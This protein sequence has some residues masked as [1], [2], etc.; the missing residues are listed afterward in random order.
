MNSSYMF[1][2]YADSEGPFK[3]AQSDQDRRCL[4]TESLGTVEYV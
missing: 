3:P 2:V 1:L 4:L